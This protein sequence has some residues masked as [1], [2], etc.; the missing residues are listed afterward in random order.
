[1]EQS[2]QCSICKT[3][4]S[5]LRYL[6]EH[7]ESLEHADIIRKN[8]KEANDKNA[9]LSEQYLSETDNGIPVR[10]DRIIADDQNPIF[11]QT[12]P[13]QLCN[14]SSTAYYSFCD[15]C[16][17]HFSGLEPYQQ[18]IVSAAHMKKCLL[19]NCSL[20][21][22]KS[23]KGNTNV[24]A[25]EIC[26]KNFSGPVPYQQH[27]NSEV[28]KK[29]LNSQLLLEKV[30]EMAENKCD[31]IAKDLLHSSLPNSSDMA[32]SEDTNHNDL[33]KT[34]KV[35]NDV[36]KDDMV[37]TVVCPKWYCITCHKQC[38]GP[39]PYEQH[40]SSE[41]HRK[42][43]RRIE[44]QSYFPKMLQNKTQDNETPPADLSQKRREESNDNEKNLNLQDLNTFSPS[45][46]CNICQ[47]QCT[48]PV[49][50]QQHMSSNVHRKNQLK[51]EITAQ[52]QA[53]QG[54]HTETSKT[55]SSSC[56]PESNF[57]EKLSSFYQKGVAMENVPMS[58][59]N[60][61]ENIV[62]PSTSSIQSKHS[63]DDPSLQ[64]VAALSLKNS[65]TC[66]SNDNLN[67]DNQ[68]KNYCQKDLSSAILPNATVMKENKIINSINVSV[69]DTD[70]ENNFRNESRKETE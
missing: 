5:E 46:Y 11:P 25:C 37:N 9:V 57:T 26:N 20:G 40:M 31:N 27:L 32:S 44:D 15:I 30:K 64:N 70:K 53:T 24:L 56:Q 62:S 47:K 59:E 58:L 55:D 10:D 2:F 14:T 19:Q 7:F 17:K 16:Q 28:H 42:N 13:S 29:K 21:S 38:S 36:L 68:E 51:A 8:S 43:M 18:H 6:L 35:N 4:Y 34:T 67:F 69:K 54:N 39:I 23:S 60:K 65:D 52:L 3:S 63:I 12:V 48:G 1:M 50:F 66:T 49:P 45:W 41:L 33:N 22:N 61:T